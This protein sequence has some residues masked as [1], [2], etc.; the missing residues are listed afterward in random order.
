MKNKKVFLVISLILIIVIGWIFIDEGAEIE[1]LNEEEIVSYRGNLII[2]NPGL[3]EGWH[4]SYQEEGSPGL[5]KRLSFESEEVNCFGQPDSCSR[6]FQEVEDL[7]GARVEV[8]GDLKDNFLE[9]KSIEFLEDEDCNFN[10]DHFP[11]EKEVLDNYIVDFSTNPDAEEFRTR[12]TEK[13]EE[14]PNF[15]GR[16]VYVEWG[17]G[18]RCGAGAVVDPESGEIV[19]FGILNSHGVDYELESKLLIVN[20]PSSLEY[21]DEGML[22]EEE[23]TQYFLMS[24]EGL[25]LLCE[26]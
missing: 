22:L 3:E 4:L 9:L 16:Y 10:F 23:V 18:A 17:C 2:K 6:F 26:K 21:L 20:P 1:P 13:V 7:A 25:F 5:V 11:T 24:D 8:S 19:E 14:G 12:I 15:A